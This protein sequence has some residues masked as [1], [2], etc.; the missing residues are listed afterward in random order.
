MNILTLV[1]IKESGTSS[2][3]ISQSFPSKDFK[4]DIFRN[5]Q[6]VAL[7]KAI[8]ALPEAQCALPFI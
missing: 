8:C 7:A 2:V 1:T 6:A 3:V 5:E 4:G